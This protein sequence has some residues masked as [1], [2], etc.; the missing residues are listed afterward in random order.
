VPVPDYRLGGGVQIDMAH[1]QLRGDSPVSSQGE[2]R[3][4]WLTGTGYTGGPKRGPGR[5][6][7]RRGQ[8]GPPE[9]ALAPEGQSRGSEEVLGLSHS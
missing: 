9:A 3:P 5:R 7:T 1:W 6:A 8:N 4:I 2:C